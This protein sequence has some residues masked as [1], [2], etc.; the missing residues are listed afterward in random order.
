MSFLALLTDDEHL[1]TVLWRNPATG[2]EDVND[3]VSHALTTAYLS[4]G[5]N[6]RPPLTRLFKALFTTTSLHLIM[7]MDR[8]ETRHMIMDFLVAQGCSGHPVFVSDF[9]GQM[10]QLERPH[11]NKTELSIFWHALGL[12]YDALAAVGARQ[13]DNPVRLDN[14]ERMMPAERLEI[15]KKWAYDTKKFAGVRYQ[16]KPGKRYRARIIDTAGL[17]EAVMA[18]GEAAN[19]PPSVKALIQV[20]ADSGCRISEACEL[21]LFHWWCQKNDFGQSIA[22]KDKGSDGVL[23][24][25]LYIAASTRVQLNAMFCKTGPHRTLTMQQV[26]KMAETSA[27][28]AKLKKIPL[29]PNRKGGFFDPWSIRNTYF[30]KAV[31]AAGLTVLNEDGDEEKVRPHTLRA[32]RFTIHVEYLSARAATEAQFHAGLGKIAGIMGCSVSNIYRYA[33]RAFARRNAAYAFK[34]LETQAAKSTAMVTPTGAVSHAQRM[35]VAIKNGLR[36]VLQAA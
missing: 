16:M 8:D 2:E 15:A 32:A 29:C 14:W 9:A 20:A 6:S 5:E 35:V 36:T 17:P 34:V 33:A 11:G 3:I 7:T 10:I 12:F 22:A 30:N 28:R 1:P 26:R 25:T 23:D 27:G 4:Y 19:W 24:K 31:D 21:S 18:A 13:G